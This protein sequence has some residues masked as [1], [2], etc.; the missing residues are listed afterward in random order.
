MTDTPTRA[1]PALLRYPGSKWSLAPT[2]VSRLPEHFHY[3]E[4]FFGSGAVLFN[5]PPSP[6]ELVN[7]ADGEVVNLF[8]VLRDRTDELC[9]A[10][11]STPWARDEYRTSADVAHDPV[12]RARR[13][14][15]RCWQAHAS[16]RAKM[17][18]W[19]SRGATQR[20]S[21]MSSRW[22]KLPAQLRAV[23]GRLRHVEIENRDAVEVI[24]RHRG[25]DCLIYADPPY[26]PA[27]RTQ[28]TYAH[29][30]TEAQ[31]GD[32][33]RTLLEHP[34]PVVV[35]GYHSDLYSAMLTEWDRFEMSAPKVEKGAVRTEVLWVKQ[36]R[37]GLTSD[38]TSERLKR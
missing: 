16:D 5:K 7:D 8:R 33:L 38:H 20:A 37:A 10:V 9:W 35:S 32:L 36:R 13:F 30:M 26:L 4:P 34:G 19:R 6:H 11:E 28:T 24:R 18:G 15:V 14:V 25:P 12:E 2:I 3:V 22:A 29:E 23:A 1:V 21:G 17:T 31:H 27:T